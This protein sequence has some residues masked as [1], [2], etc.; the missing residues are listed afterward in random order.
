M[1]SNLHKRIS[2]NLEIELTGAAME[3]FFSRCMKNGVMFL[4]VRVISPDKFRTVVSVGDFFLLNAFAKKYGCHIHVR[5]KRGVP[6]AVKPLRKR[7][8]L[9]FGA[10]LMA[11]ILLWFSNCVWIIRVEGCEETNQQEILTSLARFGLKTGA[12]R[13]ALPL[14]DIKTN[15]MTAHD[16]LSYLTVDFKGIQAIVHVW[17]RKNTAPRLDDKTPCDVIADRTGI[18]E[19]LKIRRGRACVKIGDTVQPGDVLASG[20]LVNEREEKTNVHASAEADLRVWHTYK[21]LIPAELQVAEG[22]EQEKKR[23]E[24]VL[25]TRRFPLQ[26][27]EKTE[28]PWYDKKINW[29][30]FAV[31]EDFHW[32]I[33]LESIDCRSYRPLKAQ[34]D[35][36]KLAELLRQRMLERMS[37]S[38]PD[39]EIL[40]YRFHLEK[41]GDGSYLGTLDAETLE[42]CGLEVPI[43]LEEP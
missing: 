23:Y 25:G 27:I 33:A 36:G 12:I 15:V 7:W 4:Q 40:S 41:N 42:T 28:G 26:K 39:A 20:I 31:C 24:I 3:R 9:C 43:N 18:I 6:F 10:I 2:G 11:A 8:G 35:E 21:A 29:N 38:M 19:S 14:R 22:T 30:K 34:L 1:L 13:N 5:K 17:E 16:K 32:P 37:R